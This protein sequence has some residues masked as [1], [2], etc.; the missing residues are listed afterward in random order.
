MIEARTQ[1]EMLDNI[2][3]GIQTLREGGAGTIAVLSKWTREAKVNFEG[4]RDRGVGHVALLE[5]DGTIESSVT[6]AP[7]LLTKGLEFDAVILAGLHQKNFTESEFDKRLLY[8][9]CSRA[10]H[11]LHVHW[12]GRLSDVFRPRR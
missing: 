6:V 11:W 7:V 12:F 5:M 3:R 1:S 4:L 9:G 10:R 2:A 8:L